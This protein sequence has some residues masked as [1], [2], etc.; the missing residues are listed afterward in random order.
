MIDLGERW[1]L[2][3]STFSAQAEDWLNLIEIAPHPF[4]KSDW[5]VCW[6]R[7]GPGHDRGEIETFSDLEEAFAC[8]N[9]RLDAI[10]KEIQW[11]AMEPHDG[12]RDRMHRDIE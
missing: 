12:L 4:R 6:V 7:N 5:Q 8:A 10:S 1:S 9:E 3:G 11:E 2:S